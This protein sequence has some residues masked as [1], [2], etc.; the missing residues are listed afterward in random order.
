MRFS[1]FRTAFY[2]SLSLIVRSYDITAFGT[3]KDEMSG[4]R[5]EIGIEG[6]CALVGMRPIFGMRPD[7][8]WSRR[9]Y[10]STAIP[11]PPRLARRSDPC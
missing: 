4:G 3:V 10:S 6:Q 8:Q 7:R 11:E 5:I 1:V 9:R 2:E